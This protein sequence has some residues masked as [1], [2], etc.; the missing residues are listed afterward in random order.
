MREGV[1]V[2][3]ERK[4]LGLIFESSSN[5][6]GRGKAEDVSRESAH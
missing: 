6:K 4:C 3:K 2:A 1:E 5:K